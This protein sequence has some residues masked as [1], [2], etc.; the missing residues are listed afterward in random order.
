MLSAKETATLANIQQVVLKLPTAK[1]IA[2]LESMALL[3]RHRT[4]VAVTALLGATALEAVQRRSVQMRVQQVPTVLGA[5]LLLR[6]LAVL[7][8]STVTQRVLLVPFALEI[9]ILGSSAA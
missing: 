7:L 2:P 4:P 1:E 3:D 5:Q 9:A 6:A 8:E